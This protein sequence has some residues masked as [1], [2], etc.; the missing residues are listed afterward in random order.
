MKPLLCLFITLW[1]P[2]QASAQDEAVNAKVQQ[3]AEQLASRIQARGKTRVGVLMLTDL[4]NYPTELGKY[5]AVKLESYLLFNTNLRITNRSQLSKLLEE[6]QL[7]AKGILNPD[8]ALKLQKV[9]SVEVV[10]IGTITPFAKYVDITAQAL[11]LQGAEAIASA[12]TSVPRTESIDQLIRTVVGSDQQSTDPGPRRDFSVID[13]P[14]AECENQGYNYGKYCFENRFDEPLLLYRTAA[15]YTDDISVLI[16]PGTV[17][18]A[19]LINLEFSHSLDTRFYFKT[20]REPI[21]EGMISLMVNK[22]KSKF[23]S[24]SVTNLL[25]K[26]PD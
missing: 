23:Q 18:C 4:Q 9:T 13:L 12:E 7:T 2:F 6:N 11:D 3:L 8:G 21:R 24:L 14:K 1:L 15:K 26:R 10:V 20:T 19:P 22:C 16:A 17:G 5:L 25:L